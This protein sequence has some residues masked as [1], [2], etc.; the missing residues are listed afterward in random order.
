MM[1]FKAEIDIM[2]HNEEAKGEVEAACN[3][4]VVDIIPKSYNYKITS[5]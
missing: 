1:K 2:Q 5:T 3:K 4:L